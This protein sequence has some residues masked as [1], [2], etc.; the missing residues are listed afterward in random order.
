MSP[1]RVI[2]T[3]IFDVV[4]A[5]NVIWRHTRLLSTIVPPGTGVHVVPVQYCTSKSLSPYKENVIDG[6]GVKGAV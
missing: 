4:T 5:G 6:V 1:V 3:R 2:Q